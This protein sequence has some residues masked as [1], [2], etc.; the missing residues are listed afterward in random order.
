MVTIKGRN[1]LEDFN[2][3]EDIKMDLKEIGW[4]GMVWI[5]LAQDRDQGQDIM[6]MTMNL[7]FQKSWRLS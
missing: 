1:H 4:V 7:Q 3:W 5:C 2:I 6:K